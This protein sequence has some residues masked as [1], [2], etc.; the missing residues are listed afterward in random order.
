MGVI[1]KNGKLSS[2]V[3]VTSEPI[4]SF[5]LTYWQ[6]KIYCHAGERGLLKH[7][8]TLVNWRQI[9]GKRQWASELHTMCRRSFLTVSKWKWME[10]SHIFL[11][12]GWG[13]VKWCL[14]WHTALTPTCEP[15]TRHQHRFDHL[16]TF[17]SPHC[18]Y[19]TMTLFH[20]C[21]A[22][23]RRSLKDYERRLYWKVAAFYKMNWTVPCTYNIPVS[24]YLRGFGLSSVVMI[25]QPSSGCTSCT[26]RERRPY[27]R[28]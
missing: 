5:C 9:T 21:N 15:E 22:P 8:C 3:K 18:V 14:L 7:Y 4:L 27:S 28:A 10:L 19:H 11:I 17:F 23:K 24:M 16:Y 1:M 26:V 20:Q 2:R 25:T 6:K 13:A 12:Q